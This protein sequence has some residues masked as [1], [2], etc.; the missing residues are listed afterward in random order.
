[1][2]R[3]RQ[4]GFV[5]AGFALEAS[6]AKKKESAS[7]ELSKSVL[8]VGGDGVVVRGGLA[9][10]GEPGLEV[11]LDDLVV[12]GLLRFALSIRSGAC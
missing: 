5:A 12:E 8:D 9:A 6:E 4:D 3:K 1:M 2:A 11:L 7:Q 10:G